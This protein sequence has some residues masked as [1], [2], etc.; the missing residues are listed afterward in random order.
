LTVA[1]TAT[2]GPCSLT[3]TNTD[4]GKVIATDAVTVT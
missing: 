1:A 2:T 4:A 3:I